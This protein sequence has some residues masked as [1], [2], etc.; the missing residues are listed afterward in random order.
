MNEIAKT[1]WDN[2]LSL[3]DTAMHTEDDINAQISL[4]SMAEISLQQAQFAVNN[5]ELV[6]GLDAVPRPDPNSPV[7]LGPT[8]GPRLW[9]AGQQ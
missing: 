8:Q 4:T 6:M 5:P 2:S 3:L 9:G 1:L 7:P